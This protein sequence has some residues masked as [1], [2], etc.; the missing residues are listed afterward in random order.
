M[1]NYSRNY[2]V[3]IDVYEGTWRYFRA[4]K[5][6]NV[7]LRKV[8]ERWTTSGFDLP[9]LGIRSLTSKWEKQYFKLLCCE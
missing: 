1:R 5:E 4:N 3:R 2:S 7:N 6:N 9:H 8:S